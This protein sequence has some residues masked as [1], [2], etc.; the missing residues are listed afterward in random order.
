MGEAAP[1]PMELCRLDSRRSWGT[2]QVFFFLRPQ[3]LTGFSLFTS[4]LRPQWGPAVPSSEVRAHWATERVWARTAL[5]GSWAPASPPGPAKAN[6]WPQPGPPWAPAPP[7]KLCPV[8]QHLSLQSAPFPFPQPCLAAPPHSPQLP[9]SSF[10]GLGG[11]SVDADMALC[12]YNPP[13][14]GLPDSQGKLQD[15]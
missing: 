1:S 14:L 15:D 12:S 2:W 13:R 4:S 7:G 9:S 8:G 10:M 6:H 5:Q 11:P 3:C